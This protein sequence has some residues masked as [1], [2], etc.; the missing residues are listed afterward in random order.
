MAYVSKTEE[1][2]KL[3]AM[4]VVKG[5]KPEDAIREVHKGVNRTDKWL[6]AQ[7]SVFEKDIIV[8]QEKDHQLNVMATT[9]TKDE[10]MEATIENYDKDAFFREILAD[11]TLA[12]A[13]KDFRTL[14]EYRK[15]TAELCSF[16][17]PE[18][19]GA[20]G[21]TTNNF[22]LIGVQD[23]AFKAVSARLEKKITPLLAK[24]DKPMASLEPFDAEVVQKNDDEHKF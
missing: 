9:I 23:E 12:K 24:I 19:N 18:S 3:Y 4:L 17:K 21:N 7:I 13:H 14:L 22:N 10:M 2:K 20:T 6:D 1:R 16:N 15:F 8:K 11:A 5:V